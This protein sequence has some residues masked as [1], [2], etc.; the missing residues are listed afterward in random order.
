MLTPKGWAKALISVASGIVYEAL[1]Q[2][3]D[4][5][6]GG[7]LS[8]RFGPDL[9]TRHV[10]NYSRS[11]NTMDLILKAGPFLWPIVIASV[12]G[13]AIF[14]E[15]AQ[16]FLRYRSGHGELVENIVELAREGRLAD[17]DDACK[18]TGGPV[19]AV[20]GTLVRTLDRPK[21][22]RE[23][24]VTVSGNREIR[25]M[26][27]GLRGIAVIARIAPLLGLLGTVVGLVEAFLA[28]ST[29]QGPP[30]P[31]VLASG[32]WQALL[33]TVAGLLV[34][35]PAILSHEWLQ[36][37]V[38]DVAFQMQEAVTEVQAVVGASPNPSASHDRV[39]AKS[40]ASH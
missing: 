30:D 6:F 21:D 40:T 4:A 12:V 9:A 11:V 1:L 18:R 29:M 39:P 20:L 34:A 27:R 26:E 36:S 15:R 24:I 37:R 5:F 23:Q 38:D 32:I 8:A 3:A 19:A 28:V 13:L 10:A 22:E 16:A 7:A 31:S 35:I 17:A 33:T 25:R 14:L 2:S